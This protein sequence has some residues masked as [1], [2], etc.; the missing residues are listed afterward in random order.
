MQPIIFYKLMAS[1][2]DLLDVIY[3]R[4]YE[5]SPRK[6]TLDWIN[7]Q[8]K[9]LDLCS[10][11]ATTSIGI[12][13]YRPDAQIIGIDISNNMLR[14]AKEKLQK[15]HIKNVKLYSMDATKT[16]FINKCFD[17]VLISLVLHELDES[18]AEKILR[19]AVRVLKDDGRMIVTEWE[20]SEVLLRRILFLPI[21]LLEPKPYRIFIKKDLNE[22]F[23]KFGLEIEE[24]I[25]CDYSKV[26]MLKKRDKR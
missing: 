23:K 25:H 18:L 12:S 4:D 11:T 15:K 2:Y 8:D 1:F 5:N 22:Y 17:K 20:P 14:V 6:A 16:K 10:G 9:V 24:E 19:E 7:R 26:L 13:K 21:H 3:F